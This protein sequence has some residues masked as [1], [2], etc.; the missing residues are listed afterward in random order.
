MNIQASMQPR[1]HNRECGV[2]LN[3]P[4]VCHGLAAPDGK[5]TRKAQTVAGRRA[6]CFMEVA[7]GV[8]R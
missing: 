8:S 1:T 2:N 5:E 6:L 4:L 7:A 3:C